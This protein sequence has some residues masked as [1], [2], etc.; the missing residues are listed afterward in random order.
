MKK[1]LYRIAVLAFTLLI[2]SCT[3]NKIAGR[4]SFNLISVDQ[5]IQ[6][7]KEAY[8][9]VLTKEKVSTNKKYI[10]RLKDVSDRLVKTVG[11]DMP[12]A[13]WEFNAIESNQINAFALPGGKVAIYTALLDILTD[14]ELAYV[15]AH[16]VSHVT[17]R[18]G[19]E[20]MSQQLALQFGAVAIS[21]LLNKKSKTTANVFLAAYGLGTQ[22]GISLPYSRKNEYE[23]DKFGAIYAARAGYDPRGAIST[24]RKFMQAS[25]KQAQGPEF[26]STHPLDQSRINAIERNMPKLLE[27]YMNSKDSF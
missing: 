22:I 6:M 26:L 10:K 24:L 23:A 21:A 9:D 1:F 16:E 4:N 19:S 5:E 8:N 12:E 15:L 13:E 7:G 17:L 20:R 2:F 3:T 11:K 14:D 25:G 27:I 18:H